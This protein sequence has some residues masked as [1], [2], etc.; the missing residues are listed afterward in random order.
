MP[1]IL[2]SLFLAWKHVWDTNFS[3]WRRDSHFSWSSGPREGLAVYRANA[4]PSFLG[5]YP[6]YSGP[7]SG[8]VLSTSPSTVKYSTYWAE[9]FLVM[10]M[11]FSLGFNPA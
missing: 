4:A 1:L 6:E 9:L 7:V 2:V 10:F 11:E 5:C 3:Y 8:I